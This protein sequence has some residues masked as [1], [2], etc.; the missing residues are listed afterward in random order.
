ML[1]VLKKLLLTALLAG[2]V[3]LVIESIPDMR[4]YLRIRR[5]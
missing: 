3:F 5:M 1:T 4:R 2:L